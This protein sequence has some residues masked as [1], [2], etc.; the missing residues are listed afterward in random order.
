MIRYARSLRALAVCLSLLAGYVDAIG[1]MALG[2]FFVSF[3][4]GNST[5]LS[6]GLA[7]HSHDAWVAGGL[8]GAFVIGVMFGSAVGRCASRRRTMTILA[9]VALLLASGGSLAALGARTAALAL[10]A[11][12]MGAE[13]TVFERDGEVSIGV[14]YM[15]GTLVKLGQRATGALFG[16]D[17]TGWLPYLWLWLGL[18][19]GAVL[20]AAC[21]PRLGLQAL[22]PAAAAALALALA[23]ARLEAAEA[24]SNP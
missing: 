6:V 21:Y 7:H 13:N 14:T 19:C 5:R 10:V 2:G 8:I 23:S 11:M 1:F 15:T 18:V 3:M 17:P 20:G 22:W 24:A 16:E 12:A 4:S 9:L